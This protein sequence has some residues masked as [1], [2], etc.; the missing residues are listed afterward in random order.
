[1]TAKSAKAQFFQYTPPGGPE[2]QP[3]SRKEE[4]ERQIDKA[5]YHLGPFHIAPWAALHDVSYVRNFFAN[6]IRTPNDL[7]ATAGA[8]FRAYLRNGR[9]AAWT[10][11]VLPEYVWWRD[12]AD[13]RQ[14]NGRYLVAYSGFF[15]RLTLDVR[16]GREQQQRVVTPELPIPVSARRDLGEVLAEVEITPVIHAFASSALNHQNNLVEEGSGLEAEGLRLLDRD[17][18]VTRAG[19]RWIPRRQWS[20]SLGAERS[21]VDFD[22]GTL[23]RSNAG[24]APVAE[25][26][27]S[28]RRV[29]FETDIAARSLEARQGAQFVPYDRVT[30]SA[31]LRLGSESHVSTNLYASRNLVYSL[32]PSYAY[33]TDDR[34]GISL[35][36]RLGRRAQGRV[37]VEQG[38]EGYTAYLAGAPPREDE[39]SSYGATVI[40]NLRGGFNLT[41][42]GLRAQFDSNLPG[43][44]RNYSVAGA[45]IDFLGFK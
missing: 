9:K 27:F 29:A 34:L 33:L 28:G 20:I 2:Q 24:T 32:S 13:R 10:F 36:S 14:I 7:T 38:T 44:D 42:Q 40:I 35:T 43:G 16:G 45:A 23:D 12:Q 31:S 39:L 19:L 3:E 22:H 41:L 15:N 6:G 30:G 4:L 26:R 25:V 21:E 8:G 37:F 1:M 11:Q 5:P 17:E 18:L